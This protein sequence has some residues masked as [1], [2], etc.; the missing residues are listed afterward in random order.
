MGGRNLLYTR[1][2][3]HIGYVAIIVV[4]NGTD[5]PEQEGGG[6]EY[7]SKPTAWSRRAAR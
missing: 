6:K 1:M 2:V 7:G 3:V 4:Y 5:V